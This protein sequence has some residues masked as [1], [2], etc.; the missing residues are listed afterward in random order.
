[1]GSGQRPGG[2]TGDLLSESRGKK[3]R[4]ASNKRSCIPLKQREDLF[5]F[6]CAVR[7]AG[8]IDVDLAEAVGALFG[9]GSGRSFLCRFFDRTLCFVNCLNHGEEHKGHQQEVDYGG[10][11]VAVGKLRRILTFAER[12]GPVRKI[13]SSE[14]SAE[15]RHDNVVHERVDNG[16][17]CT[18]NDNAD[19]QIHH[20]ALADE[21]FKFGNEFFHDW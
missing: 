8:G 19:G 21:F 4:D 13:K 10:D 17:E 3:K 12:N 5:E 6:A 11:K 14:Q 20:V 15:N 9:G 16:L 2:I 1:M 18:A 7:A